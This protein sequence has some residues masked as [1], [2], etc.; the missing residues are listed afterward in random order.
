M[1]THHNLNITPP[2]PGGNGINVLIAAAMVS[3]ETAELLL[4]DPL[5]AAR[6]GYNGESITLSPTEA[7]LLRAA[8]GAGSVPEL[9]RRIMALSRPAHRHD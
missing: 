6:R 2:L 4:L 1:N 9:C 8:H 7:R 5:E 3:Q